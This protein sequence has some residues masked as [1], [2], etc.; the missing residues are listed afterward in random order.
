[1][2]NRSEKTQRGNP[3]QLTTRQH[4]YPRKSIERFGAAVELMDLKRDRCRSAKPNDAIFCAD[5]AWNHG[6]EHGF[7]KD[8]E[9]R[10]QPLATEVCAGTRHEFDELETEAV[11]EF[12]G[13]W[14]SRAK[15]RNLP[16]QTIRSEGVMGAS[17]DYGPDGLERLERN[18]IIAVRPDGSFAMRDLVAPSIR[19]DIDRIRNGIGSWS[20]GVFTA[21]DGEFCVPDVPSCGFIPISPTI[22]LSAGNPS[23][24]VD[25]ERT[26]M[27]NKLLS[28]GASDYVF[29]RSLDAC[30]GLPDPGRAARR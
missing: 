21:L 11:S 15:R 9:D 7:M 18:N 2:G 19:L 6:A 12:Y 17:V 10:F 29:A 3:H 16:Y 28:S 4:V 30:P 23:S 27:V 5:R 25:L 22:L 13:L 8:I 1:M 14:L 26:A 20:W 24:D